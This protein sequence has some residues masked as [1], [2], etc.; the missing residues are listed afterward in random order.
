L[1]FSVFSLNSF[2]KDLQQVLKT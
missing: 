2:I 1:I